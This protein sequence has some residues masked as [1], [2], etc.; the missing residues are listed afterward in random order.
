[1]DRLKTSIVLQLGDDHPGALVGALQSLAQHGINLTKLES[2]P[3]REP[4]WSYYFFLDLLGHREQ[5]QVQAVLRDIRTRHELALKVIGAYPCYS[6]RPPT[7]A[8]R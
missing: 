8:P 1:P 2:R 4:G 5:P 3:T 7:A 6:E